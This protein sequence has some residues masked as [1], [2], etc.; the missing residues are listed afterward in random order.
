MNGSGVFGRNAENLWN[1][2]HR[3]GLPFADLDV[4]RKAKTV[5][6][7]SDRFRFHLEYVELPGFVDHG[8]LM[9]SSTVSK[10][11]QLPDRQPKAEASAIV[12]DAAKPKTDDAKRTAAAERKRRQREREKGSDH[13]FGELIGC[14]AVTRRD[15]HA[16]THARLLDV[17]LSRHTP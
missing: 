10:G 16:V 1:M 15:C 6:R 4:V 9:K 13:G 7:V 8:R 11:E 14:H 12:A 17:T 3:E 5:G 2:R